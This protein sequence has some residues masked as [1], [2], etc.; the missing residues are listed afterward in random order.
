MNPGYPL[1]I[2]EQRVYPE[3]YRGRVFIWDIDKTYL[4]TRFSSLRGLARIPI[5]FAVDKL[6][7]PGMPETLR[8]LRRGVGKRF[9]A[10]PIYFISASPPQ[11]RRVIERK[12]LLDGVEH[13]G[14]VFKNWLA[15]LRGFRPGR[16]R[17]QVGFKLCALLACRRPRP[18]SREVLFGDDVESDALAFSLYARLL[19]GEICPGDAEQ[20][21]QEAGVKRDDRRCIQ[22][23][24]D[25]LGGRDGRV[26]RIFINLAHGGEPNRLPDSPVPL[27]A[28]RGGFQ[29][30]LACLGAGYVDTET[31]GQAARACR[32]RDPGCDTRRLLDDAVARG[33]LDEKSAE[34][35]GRQLRKDQ[36][37]PRP[38]GN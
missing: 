9:A 16:L 32:Q 33:L 15:A 8:G 20:A 1:W 6:A 11:M 26:E 19:T 23:L 28:V 36:T 31:V 21:L 14:L 12:M 37:G 24:L 10:A 5:E 25:E 22:S 7:I 30:A 35:A 27:L 38:P 17:E 3:G 13:D 2:S 4:D 18:A 29:M 34:H